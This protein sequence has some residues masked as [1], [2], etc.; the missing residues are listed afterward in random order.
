MRMKTLKLTKTRLLTKEKALEDR[1]WYLFDASGK[2][3]GRFASEIAKVLRGKHKVD[4]S[5]TVDAGDGV[6]IV[7][8]EKIEVT[9]G[10]EA[11]KVYKKHTG[12]VGGLKETPYRVLKQ[13]HPE[14][15]IFLA[16]R[17]MMPKSRLAKNQLKKLRIYRGAEHDMQA[18][19]P[20]IVNS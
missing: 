12:F 2:I 17:G 18:Q 6:I 5:P 13:K 19:K 16:V 20:I 7:N 8:A 15:V 11:R 4:Y 9:G 1:R 10:K 14:E 3:L